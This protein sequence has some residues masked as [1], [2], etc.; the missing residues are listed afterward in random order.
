MIKK[1]EENGAQWSDSGDK[2]ITKGGKFLRRTRLDELPQLFNI[3]KDDMSFVGPRPE[4]PEFIKILKEQI[5]HY[6]LRH[7]IKP[8]L[9]GWAQ[10][11]YPYGSSDDDSLRKLSFDLY[12]L[13]NRDFVLDLSIMLRTIAVVLK[14]RGR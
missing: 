10:I 14:F 1:A 12:Y 6:P 13:K 8:G 7:L 9:T 2:R 5:P 11:N 3:F 4:R